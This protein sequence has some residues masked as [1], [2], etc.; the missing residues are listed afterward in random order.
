MTVTNLSRYEQGVQSSIA[1]I[2]HQIAELNARR[3][4]LLNPEYTG[5]EHVLC[6]GEPLVWFVT[7]PN[8]TDAR[9]VSIAVFGAVAKFSDDTRRM[10]VPTSRLTRV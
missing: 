7:S 10:N 1:D 8:P 3:H 4:S 6:D 5:G 9:L 2:D